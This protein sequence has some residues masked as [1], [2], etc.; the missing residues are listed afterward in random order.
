MPEPEVFN[1]KSM[2]FWMIQGNSGDTYCNCGHG[3][4]DSIVK[5]AEDANRYYQE[6]FKKV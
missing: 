5:A 3:W 6:V 2:Y 4:A 1:G